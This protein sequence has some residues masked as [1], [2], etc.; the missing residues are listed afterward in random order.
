MSKKI[1]RFPLL[2]HPTIFN[3]FLN[4]VANTLKMITSKR[5]QIEMYHH[6]IIKCRVKVLRLYPYFCGS[7]S[8]SR[9]SRH[10]LKYGKL[11]F[12]IKKKYIFFFFPLF[13]SGQTLE[14][15]AQRGCGHSKLD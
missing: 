11:H 1:I 6:H 12:N 3:C 15:A 7:K 5:V 14:E 13:E 10:K 4:A 9:G 2:Y 8:R